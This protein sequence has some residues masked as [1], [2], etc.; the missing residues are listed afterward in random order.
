MVCAGL[1]GAGAQRRWR[2]AAQI[3]QA[4]TGGGTR[5][6]PRL[7]HRSC[8]GQHVRVLVVDIGGS[9]VKLH[10]H[11]ERFSARFDSGDTLTPIALMQGIRDQSE[12]WPF[13]A[14][15][16]GYP[17]AVGPQGPIRE[18]GNLGPGWVGFDFEN[19]FQ[20][21]VR[22]V[23][24]AVLQA[25][26]CYDGG[27]MLFLSLGTGLGSALIADHVAVPLELGSITHNKHGT[28]ADH[29]GVAGLEAAGAAAWSILVTDIVGSLLRGTAADYV[30]LGGGNSARLAELP[31]KA[32]RAGP[33][34]AVDGGVRLWE[35]VVEPHDRQPSRVWRIL[36]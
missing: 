29:V 8:I 18:A 21:P 14:V 28:I 3:G 10:M 6:Q 27:R 25:L 24:D 15:S 12:G 19:A 31:P 23:N 30:V 34:A 35:E 11:G 5:L 33:D 2:R 9:H 20:R 32:R 36:T 22:I 13:D 16:V 1:A 4:Q 17:G 7:R 26:G